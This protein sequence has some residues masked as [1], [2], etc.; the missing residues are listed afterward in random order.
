MSFLKTV[1][2]LDKTDLSNLICLF[3]VALFFW[4]SITSLLP[5]IPA[6]IQDL[7]ATDRQIAFVMGSFALG[8]LGSRMWL[9]ALADQ[10]SRKIVIVIGTIVA[11]IAPIGYVLFPIIPYLMAVRAFHGVAIAAFTTGYS[12]LVVDLAPPKQKGELIGYMSLSIPIGMAIGPALGGFL[13]ETVNYNLLFTISSIFAIISLILANQIKETPIKNAQNTDVQSKV[14]RENTLNLG[15]LFTSI[16]FIIP[17]IVL[18]LV[19]C[20]FGTL[21]TFLPLYIRSLNID[22]NVGIFYSV[23][24]LGSFIVRLFS[25]QASDKYGRGLF[26]S[27]SLL[28]YFLAMIFISIGNNSVMFL[29]AAIF[30]GMGAGMIIPIILALISD[31][32]TINERGKVFAFCTSGF[33]VGIALGAVILGTFTSSLGYSLTFL[34]ASFLAIMALLIFASFSNKNLQLSFR[35]AIGNAQDY[36]AIK[37]LR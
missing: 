5:V 35:F 37:N 7:G 22:F 36:Y 29:S 33:D 9:G 34:L 24:A 27:I 25:G 4:T 10:H 18:F 32:C 8:L 14:I 19:G 11:V 20:I 21:V 23:T 31:R 17:T 13:G 30:E 26:V 15:Q 6:Y 2:D 28:L 12:A 1:R 16:P 3:I